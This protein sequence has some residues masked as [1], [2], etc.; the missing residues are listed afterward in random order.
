MNNLLQNIKLFLVQYNIIDA[1]NIFFNFDETYNDLNINKL[2]LLSKGGESSDIAYKSVVSVIAKNSAMSQ[3]ETL[4][5]NAFQVLCSNNGFK[6]FF[7]NGH[8]MMIKSL[9]PPVYKEKEK[10]GRHVFTF[11]ILITHN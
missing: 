8:L 1:D 5:S 7:F 2:I 11:D 4:I 3:A 9:H 6:P 10:N